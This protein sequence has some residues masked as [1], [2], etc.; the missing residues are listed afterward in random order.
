[1][2]PQL[3]ILA[4]SLACGRVKGACKANRVVLLCNSTNKYECKSRENEVVRGLESYEI[5]PFFAVGAWT[6]IY[7]VQV[8]LPVDLRLVAYFNRPIFRYLKKL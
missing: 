3:L 4:P 6:T 8:L 5:V 2:K 7:V 1:M